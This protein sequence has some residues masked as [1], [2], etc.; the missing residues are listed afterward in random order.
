MPK[1][2]NILKLKLRRKKANQ[3]KLWYVSCNTL[4][5][6]KLIDSS[7]FSDA[8]HILKCEPEEWPEE[9][10]AVELVADF[11]KILVENDKLKNK[12]TYENHLRDE[13]FKLYQHLKMQALT[14]CIWAVSLGN[15]ESAS[16][17]MEAFK[18]KFPLT[19][20]ELENQIKIL[21][22]W[23][24]LHEE[25]DAQEEKTP[26]NW[27]DLIAYVEMNSTIKVDY[28]C[29]VAQYYAYERMIEQMNIAR[30]KAY[31]HGKAD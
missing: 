7:N 25:K 2:Q 11:E 5:M 22:N 13:D 18:F 10:N 15:I 12:N 31:E 19:I 9:I 30:K 4:P 16:E 14:T 1:F 26:V 28:N 29:P 21:S 27:F 23:F 24:V 3:S 17:I 8:R 6:R 20:A